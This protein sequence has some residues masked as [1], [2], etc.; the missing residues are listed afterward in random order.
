VVAPRLWPRAL[1]ASIV[2]R[3]RAAPQCAATGR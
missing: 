3:R 1:T 2:Q